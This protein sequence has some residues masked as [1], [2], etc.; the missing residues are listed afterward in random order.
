MGLDMYLERHVH[1]SNYDFSPEDKE[2]AAAVLAALKVAN[3]DVYKNSSITVKLCAGYWRKANAIHRWFVQNVQ[4]GA[5]N[6]QPFYVSEEN[7]EA[8]RDECKAVLADRDDAAS[9]LPTQSG[10]FF[11]STDYD[12]YYFQDLER[13]VEICEAALDPTNMIAGEHNNFYYRASW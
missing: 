12:E 2:L 6:C 9:L 4:D 10:F 7:L 11:G 5:D 13:T 3:P 8:L 1:I